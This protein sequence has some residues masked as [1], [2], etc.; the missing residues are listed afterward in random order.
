VQRWRTI[1]SAAALLA[2][3]VIVTGDDPAA[4]VGAMLNTSHSGHFA[5]GEGFLIVGGPVRGLHPGSSQ[6]IDIS[7]RNLQ[8][9]PIRVRTIRARVATTSRRAC[10][11]DPS[12]LVIRP[13]RGRL[14]VLVNTRGRTM[15]GSFE[16]YMPHSV[17]NACKNVVFTIRFTGQ[18]EQV[19]R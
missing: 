19:R 6:R 10:R 15:P 1:T 13:F 9:Q 14:P 5:D 11:P 2:A 7:V 12:N 17:S 3:T 4:Q 8:W 16:V 18:A